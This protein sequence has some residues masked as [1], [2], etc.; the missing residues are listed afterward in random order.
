M[1][2]TLTDGGGEGGLPAGDVPD[3]VAAAEALGITQQ[4]L[5]AALGEPLPDFQAAAATLGITVQELQ[6]ALG[7][8]PPMN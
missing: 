5:I 1:V 2:P 7:V 8:A 6:A 4:E 3:L